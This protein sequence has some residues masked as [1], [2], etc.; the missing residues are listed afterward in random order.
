MKMI[1]KNIKLY[2]KYFGR[3]VKYSYAGGGFITGIMCGHNDE[4]FCI[5]KVDEGWDYED[6]ETF[7]FIHDNYINGCYC[8]IEADNRIEICD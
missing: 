5:L 7:D 3:K 6:V 4:E 8:Y 2:R 1:P